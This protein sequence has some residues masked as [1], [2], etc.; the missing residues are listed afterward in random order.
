[1]MQPLEPSHRWLF[2]LDSISV[3]N[4]IFIKRVKNLSILNTF[5]NNLIFFGYVPLYINFFKLKC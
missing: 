1:M 4:Q 5:Q 2:S 3:E